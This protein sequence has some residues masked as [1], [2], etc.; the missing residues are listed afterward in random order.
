M[1]CIGRTWCVDGRLDSLELL[2]RK[3]IVEVPAF[4]EAIHGSE[5]GAGE[6]VKAPASWQRSVIREG[7]ILCCE[8]VSQ[9]AC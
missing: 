3:G 7:R 1:K 4:V 8:G 5:F 9:R 2:K 6:V